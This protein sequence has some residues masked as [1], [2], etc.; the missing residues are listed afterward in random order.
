MTRE[1][2]RSETAR[3]TFDDGRKGKQTVNVFATDEGEDRELVEV[4]VT[5]LSDGTRCRHVYAGV[6]DV[7]AKVYGFGDVGNVEWSID[8]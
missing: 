8:Q 2:L 3:V 1:F 4:V 6:S 5:R 7:Q